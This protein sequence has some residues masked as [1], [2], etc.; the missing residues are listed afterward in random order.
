MNFTEWLAEQ[1]ATRRTDE[2]ADFAQGVACHALWP[3]GGRNLETFE[4]FVV[5]EF[6]PGP[7]K[8]LHRVWNEY[9]RT[10]APR[11]ESPF[12]GMMS[13]SSPKTRRT[14]RKKA[15]SDPPEVHQSTGIQSSNF[16]AGHPTLDKAA[17]PMKPP[18]R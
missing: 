1:A 7:V 17:L 12:G 16:W 13:A 15:D 14:T 3:V 4:D 8:V 6:G 5:R 18:G 11:V 10:R 9:D 2:T